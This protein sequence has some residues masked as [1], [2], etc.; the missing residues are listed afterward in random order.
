MT[1]T[2]FHQTGLTLSVLIEATL[3]NGEETSAVRRNMFCSC[4]MNEKGC[5][6]HCGLK[7][8]VKTFTRLRKQLSQRGIKSRQQLCKEC[9][10][11]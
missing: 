9:R 5:R 6:V 11:G 3:W 2:F 10:G 4:M 7:R 8:H 1:T